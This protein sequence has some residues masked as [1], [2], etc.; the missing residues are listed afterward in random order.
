MSY[1][2]KPGPMPPVEHKKVE[3][4]KLHKLGR[5]PKLRAAGAAGKAFSLGMPSID[6]KETFF[7]DVFNVVS[8]LYP[9]V[10]P[11]IPLSP[12]MQRN[13]DQSN[14]NASPARPNVIAG[15]TGSRSVWSTSRGKDTTN[16]EG[17]VG[18][19]WQKYKDHRKTENRHI[20]FI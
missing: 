9:C 16:P 19:P 3:S 8:H 18:P 1:M 11:C 10:R 13:S 14:H 6:G 5:F 20:K 7:E 2:V 4:K 12:H 15:N 17:W